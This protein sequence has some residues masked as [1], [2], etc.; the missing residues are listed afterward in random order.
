MNFKI[1]LF[2]ISVFIYFFPIYKCVF[3]HLQKIPEH[4]IFA[5]NTSALPITEI[6]KA[7]KRP[8]KVSTKSMTVVFCINNVFYHRTNIFMTKILYLQVVGMHYFSPVDKMQLLEIIPGK[9]TSPDTL[10]NNHKKVF[11]I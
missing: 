3:W 4:C 10:G 6:A 1:Y 5:S 7:S 11:K 9:E 2:C 8:D